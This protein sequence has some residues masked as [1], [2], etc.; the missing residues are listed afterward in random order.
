MA[1]VERTDEGFVPV[2]RRSADSGLPRRERPETLTKHP[3][4]DLK[5]CVAQL[6]RSARERGLTVDFHLEPES[7]TIVMTDVDAS[8]RRHVI[9]QLDLDEVERLVALLQAG[10]QQ[11][12]DRLV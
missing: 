2:A 3:R 4:P 6:R 5:K 11:L 12:L 7:T 10:R 9:R 8:G 1:K